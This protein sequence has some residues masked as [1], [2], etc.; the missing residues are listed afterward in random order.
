[1]KL[2][3]IYTFEAPREV[4][5]QAL[6]DPEVLAKVMP[7]CEK[8]DRVGDN[9][10]EGM[11][12]IRVGPVQGKFQGKVTLAD[13]N[14]PD[15]YSMVVDGKGAPGFMKGEGLVQLEDQGSSTLMHYTGDAQVGGRIA[16]VGQ[17]LLDSSAKALTKQS[18]DGLHKLIQA[19]LQ[20][21]STGDSDTVEAGSRVTTAQASLPEVEAPSEMQFAIGVAKNMVEDLLPP[22][23]RPILIAAG[24]GA[25]A[26][27]LFL[28]WWANVVARKVANEIWER[29]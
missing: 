2:E 26:F 6:L 28:N 20:V 13:I 24:L 22:E 25:L 14:E 18:L 5:W 11:I 9:E 27:F 4:V 23:R 29:R 17:R 8:L 7:G 12:K 21:N 15:S 19:R 16:S 10:Y 3:G 1:M